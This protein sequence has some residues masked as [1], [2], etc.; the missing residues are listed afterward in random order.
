VACSIGRWGDRQGVERGGKGALARA[1][2]VDAMDGRGSRRRR[3]PGRR[4]V[5]VAAAGCSA[6]ALPGAGWGCYSR[7][8]W[9]SQPVTRVVG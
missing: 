3:V 2:G 8:R 7:R 5:A 6:D 4:T 1:A 9:V